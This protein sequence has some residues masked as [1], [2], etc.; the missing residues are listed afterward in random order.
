MLSCLT[1]DIK[2][3]PGTEPSSI[4]EFSSS[5]DLQN[6]DYKVVEHG[7]ANH[8]K[9]IYSN[10]IIKPGALHTKQ[11]YPYLLRRIRR[12]DPAIGNIIISGQS[13]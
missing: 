7:S 12:E 5:L 10:Q 6:A 1:G 4:K 8:L 2:I 3:S 13:V 9:D 11:K